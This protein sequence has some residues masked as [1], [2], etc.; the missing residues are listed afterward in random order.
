MASVNIIVRGIAMTYHKDDGIWRILFPFGECHMVKFKTDEGDPGIELAEEGRRIRI[1][2]EGAKS[3]FG[4][5]AGYD[6]FLDLTAEYSH[7]NGIKI[8]DN[9]NE[10]AVLMM[11]ESGEYSV[12][13]YTRDEHLM[14]RSNRVTLSPQKIAYS[15]KIT[16]EADKVIVNVDGLNDFPKVFDSDSTIIFDNDCHEGE[17]RKISDLEMVYNIVEDAG[18]ADE[19]CVVAKASEKTSYDL[20]RGDFYGDSRDSSEGGLPCHGIVVSKSENLP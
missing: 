10:N 15:S 18:R 5:G 4:M 17:H 16:I 1:T 8:K 9:W 7:S 13:E 20:R 12:H 6:T 3:S 19:Q 11:I 14:A 2:T